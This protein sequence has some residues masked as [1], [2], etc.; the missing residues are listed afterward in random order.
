M[1]CLLTL[2]S[3]TPSSSQIQSSFLPFKVWCPHLF[4]FLNSPHT[5]LAA[6]LGNMEGW[7]FTGAWSAS[8]GH[9]WSRLT[10]PPLSL[11][12]VNLC[13][14]CIISPTSLH[15]TGILSVLSLCRSWRTV[16]TSMSSYVQRPCYI[17]KAVFHYNHLPLSA[18]TIFLSSLS[19]WSLDFEI[20][21]SDT[22]I[23]F[24]ADN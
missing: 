18:L 11:L 15:R 9:S 21:W 3:S 7:T 17:W 5:I 24:K 10:L 14:K 8:R 12:I 23:S 20:V 19:Q 1:E 13:H 22:N 16:S 4:L 6:H 2:F